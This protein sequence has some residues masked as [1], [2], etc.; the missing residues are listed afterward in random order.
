MQTSLHNID[1]VIINGEVKKRNGQ[2]LYENLN[3]G[4][5]KLEESGKRLMKQLR[6]AAH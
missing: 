2:L 5:L 1:T 3:T 4:K 6:S